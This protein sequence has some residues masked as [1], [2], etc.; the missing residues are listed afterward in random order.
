MVRG[1]CAFEY[2]LGEWK[3]DWR[4]K[5][6]RGYICDWHGLTLNHTEYRNA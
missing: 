3:I 6:S 1:E 5:G 2:L 4:V